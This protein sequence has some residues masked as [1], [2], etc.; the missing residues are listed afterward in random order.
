MFFNLLLVMPVVIKISVIG[1]AA[2]FSS[3]EGLR[4]H[5]K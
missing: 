5:E 4:N 3:K 1:D 2:S